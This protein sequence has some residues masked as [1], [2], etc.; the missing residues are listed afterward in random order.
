M[1]E[2]KG[3]KR[4]SSRERRR[5]RDVTAQAPAIEAPEPRA[6]TP[7]VARRAV[8]SGGPLPSR[9]ARVTGFM[10]AVVTAFLAVVMVYQAASGG[11][12][13][14]DAALRIAAGGALVALAVVVGL[15]SLA[16]GQV[17]DWFRRRR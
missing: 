13:G 8:P 5:D 12:S 6:A 1:P 4:R 9:T 2:R 11:S 3:R 7:S 10:L 16:P 17:R 15:L 14:I